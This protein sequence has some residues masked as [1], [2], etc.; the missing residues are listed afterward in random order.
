MENEPHLE[1]VISA[2][3]PWKVALVSCSKD[4][5]RIDFRIKY[6]S[7]SYT[8]PVCAYSYPVI[9]LVPVTWKS[10]TYEKYTAY[11]TAYL[12]LTP[13][14]IDDCQVAHNPES[15]RN[16]ILLDLIMDQIKYLASTNPFSHFR[17]AAGPVNFAYTP[18]DLTG[19]G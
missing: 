12:P 11:I 4:K 15:L 17:N 3:T 5:S 1:N 19:R 6:E 10:V 8:C 14:H 13:G 18:C 16:F 9:Q 2:P 7:A